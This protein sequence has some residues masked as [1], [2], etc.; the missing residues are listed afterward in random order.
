M[1]SLSGIKIVEQSAVFALFL[2][3]HT[4]ANFF[5]APLSQGERECDQNT[6]STT[7]VINFKR[8]RKTKVSFV[9]SLSLQFIIT[10]NIIP[11]T[12]AVSTVGV[13]NKLLLSG[14]SFRKTLLTAFPEGASTDVFTGE[15]D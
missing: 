14:G 3:L 4:S 13:M 6:L 1:K 12:I 9:H 7:F 8:K 2:V 10:Q 15:E 5:A 11:N